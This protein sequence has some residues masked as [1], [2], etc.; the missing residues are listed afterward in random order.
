MEIKKTWQ[1]EQEHLKEKG[2]AWEK[3]DWKKWVAVDDLKKLLDDYS[4]NRTEFYYRLLEALN[5]VK[6]ANSLSNENGN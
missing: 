2:G 3:S 6:I 4:G 5:L 1:I